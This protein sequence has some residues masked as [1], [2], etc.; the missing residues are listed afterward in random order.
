MRK[1]SQIFLQGYPKKRLIQSTKSFYNVI[2]TSLFMK[3]IVLLFTWYI[4]MVFCYKSFML[5]AFQIKI[6]FASSLL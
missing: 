2:P 1:S 5:R 3:V 4:F 6:Y